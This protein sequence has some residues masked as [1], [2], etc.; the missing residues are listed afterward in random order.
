MEIPTNCELLSSARYSAVITARRIA[1]S[2]AILSILLVDINILRSGG[3]GDLCRYLSP[4]MSGEACKLSKRTPPSRLG[5]FYVELKFRRTG[6]A[7]L[8]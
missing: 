4:I 7:M 5:L 3:G 2:I 6:M 8:G 1:I